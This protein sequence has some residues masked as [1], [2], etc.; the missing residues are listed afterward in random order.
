M[1]WLP[2]ADVLDAP[3]YSTGV[4]WCLAAA[5]TVTLTGLRFGT[6]FSS[7]EPFRCVLYRHG[8]SGEPGRGALT[9]PD[10][11]IKLGEFAA[12]EVAE[13]T[14]LLL[15]LTPVR[16]RNPRPHDVRHA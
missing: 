12:D 7:T 14:P 8:G 5:E 4:F 1:T 6:W 3:N 15:K 13:E 16:P 9:S 2:T 10:A 11:W